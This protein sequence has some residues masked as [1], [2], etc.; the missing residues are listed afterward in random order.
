MIQLRL[1]EA[2]GRRDEWMARLDAL[3]PLAVLDRGYA[4]ARRTR[5]GALLRRSDQLAPGEKLSI[6]LA[7]AKVEATADVIEALDR[8]DEA[9]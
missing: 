9:S 3:S 8:T 5:D 7:A 1:S 6:R 2:R 4:V